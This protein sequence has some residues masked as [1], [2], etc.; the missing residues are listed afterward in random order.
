MPLE[1]DLVN[2]GIAAQFAEWALAKGEGL[3]GKYAWHYIGIDEAREII[4]DA[5]LMA[6]RRKSD[7]DGTKTK[8]VTSQCDTREPGEESGPH[9]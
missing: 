5:I 4:K 6:L 2:E 3:G 7:F 8:G 9:I 1:N